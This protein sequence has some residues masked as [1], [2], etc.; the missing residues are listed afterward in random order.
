MTDTA[1][2]VLTLLYCPCPS[3]DVA[4]ALGRFLVTERLAACVNI[5]PEIR[6]IYR[7][8]AQITESSECVLLVK[9]TTAQQ[10]AATAALLARHPYDC[11][12]ILALPVTANPAFAAWAQEEASGGALC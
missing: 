8:E 7:W 1:A 12:A 10:E 6:S 5:L 4:T 2:P 9:T 11:P 3:L